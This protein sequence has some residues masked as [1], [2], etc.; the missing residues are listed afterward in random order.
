MFNNQNVPYSSDN[1]NNLSPAVAKVKEVYHIYRSGS[2][3]SSPSCNLPHYGSTSKPYNPYSRYQ[4]YY[5]SNRS[6]NG[7][8]LLKFGDTLTEK[9]IENELE[10]NKIVEANKNETNDVENCEKQDEIIADCLG[11]LCL[12]CTIMILG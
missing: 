6:S 5:G 8:R 4:D 10:K 11:M 3:A 2:G 9:S 1:N 12:L 7:V